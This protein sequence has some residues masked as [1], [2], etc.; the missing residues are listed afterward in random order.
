MGWCE[1]SARLS[2]HFEA[3]CSNDGINLVLPQ[4]NWQVC[5]SPAFSAHDPVFASTCRRRYIDAQRGTMPFNAATRMLRLRPKLAW[6]WLTRSATE[7]LGMASPVQQNS[8]ASDRCH[9]PHRRSGCR[10]AAPRRRYPFESGQI[11]RRSSPNPT[12][13]RAP[14][15]SAPSIVV[16]I[17]TARESDDVRSMCGGLDLAKSSKISAMPPTLRIW[18]DTGRGESPPGS[19][20][21]R[22]R[23]SRLS[24]HAH[25]PVGQI[26]CFV[27]LLSRAGSQQ[28]RF[29]FR[30][31]WS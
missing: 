1:F 24:M 2:R 13:C 9:E 14:I 15:T 22:E 21:I 25:R 29:R 28:R 23:P 18:S 11:E 6:R 4:C 26:G 3:R 30:P 12:Q 19:F 8:E 7:Q 17:L 16:G 31:C 10:P 5:R 20:G 27:H